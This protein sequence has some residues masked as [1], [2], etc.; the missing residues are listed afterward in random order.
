MGGLTRLVCLAALAL[1]GLAAALEPPR[2]SALDRLLRYV[3]IDTQS[4]E[5]QD[6]VP[7]TA[8]QFDLARLLA[9][10]L[11]TLGAE[12]VRVSEFGIVYA[13][14]RGNL[15]DTAHVPVVGFIAHLDTSP[16]APGRDVHPIVHRNYQGGDIVLPANPTR[17]LR[18][19]D[20]PR[21]GEMIGDDIVT[22]DGTT[23]LGSDDK[24]GCAE[25][26]TLLDTLQTNPSIG[27]GPLAVA[28]TPDEE[29]GGSIAHFD[30]AAFGAQVAYT[31]DGADPGEIH[32]ENFNMENVLVRFRGR[33]AG[34]MERGKVINALFAMAD[35]VGR[36]PP[37]L[38]AENTSG[39]TG[40]INPTGAAQ[41]AFADAEVRLMLRDFDLQGL[42]DKEALVRQ[43]LAETQAKYPDVPIS[44]E[45]G[46]V[47]PNMKPLLDRYPEAV[48]HAVEATRRAGLTPKLLPVR[49]GTDGAELAVR[50]LPTPNLFT[51]GGNFHGP[52][53]FN[54][55]RAMDRTV[56]TLVNLVEIYGGQG[57]QP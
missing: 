43:W 52:L 20:T 48:G 7:S 39:R 16:A 28:F 14:V 57:T 54:S 24:A 27:H 45:P 5:G 40:Y 49:G 12:E 44:L 53:E 18:P 36:I 41:P 46:P 13:R 51:G 34:G 37:E 15:P 19:V 17:V 32:D 11:T 22:A 23:L 26:L 9:A 29:I 10:E 47:H 1:P 35:F 8:N 3:R 31:V 42:R 55:R 21:L 56:E 30:I 25:I 33:M 50:G 4:R 2:E 6:T 38:R